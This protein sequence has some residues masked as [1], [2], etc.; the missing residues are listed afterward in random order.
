MSSIVRDRIADHPIEWDARNAVV[1]RI[2]RKHGI[3]TPVNDQITAL[4]RLGEP[5]EAELSNRGSVAMRP[6]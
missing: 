3:P 2:G 1:G 6:R 4:M 5:A